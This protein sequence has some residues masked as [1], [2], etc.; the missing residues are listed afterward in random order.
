MV[1][2]V[3]FVFVCVV[4]CVWFACELFCD[5]VWFVYLRVMNVFCVFVAA[6][7]VCFVGMC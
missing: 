7:I 4:M 6:V 2:Y 3:L 5:A 1:F